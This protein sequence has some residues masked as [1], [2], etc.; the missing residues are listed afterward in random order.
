M[1]PPR[2]HRNA[3]RSRQAADRSACRWSNGIAWGCSCDKWFIQC[4]FC[5]AKRKMQ[6]WH[7][8]C[9]WLC[10]FPA[11][12]AGG[13]CW[14]GGG[15]SWS[16]HDAEN[17]S[18]NSWLPC[19]WAAIFDRVWKKIPLCEGLRGA[20]AKRVRTGSLLALR[21]FGLIWNRVSSW[22]TVKKDCFTLVSRLC[23]RSIFPG[24]R[25]PEIF[26]PLRNVSAGHGDYC[27]RCLYGTR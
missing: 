6:A 15:P 26:Y 11:A 1:F 25:L 17:G 12:P 5:R 23:W 7:S 14:P 2:E 10:I 16:D 24:R 4:I 9:R 18:T 21:L 8:S 20:P 13:I 27:C 19:R 3:L 22:N